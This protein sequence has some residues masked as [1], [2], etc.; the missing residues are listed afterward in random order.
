MLFRLLS[1]LFRGSKEFSAHGVGAQMSQ[2]E[3]SERRAE[4]PAP[5]DYHAMANRSDTRAAAL[6]I[7]P[8]R[9]GRKTYS[10][11]HSETSSMSTSDIQATIAARQAE[12]K[13]CGVL[14]RVL[15]ERGEE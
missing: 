14:Y 15:A 11:R 13:E 12:G 7:D 1:N 10:E 4:E 2:R 6:H 9:P 8:P 3:P 5:V